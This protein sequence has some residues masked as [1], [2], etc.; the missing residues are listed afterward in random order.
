LSADSHLFGEMTHLFT[1]LNETARQFDEK[2]QEQQ[3]TRKSAGKF[4]EHR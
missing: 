3:T 4:Y 1:I 2:F